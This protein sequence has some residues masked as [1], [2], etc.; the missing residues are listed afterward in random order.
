MLADADSGSYTHL[1]GYGEIDFEGAAQTA[2]SGATNS[3]NPRMRQARPRTL[4]TDLGLHF[5]AG[6]SWS[7]TAPSKPASICAAWMRLASSTSSPFPASL[8]TGNLAFASGR[9]SDRN[10]K[11]RCRPKTPRRPFSAA[12]S[13]AVGTPAVGPQGVLNPESVREPHRSG[14]KLL[15][16]AEQCQP[17]PCPISPAKAAWDPRLGAYRLHVEALGALSRSLRSLRLRQSSASIP[18]AS[19]ATSRRARFRRRW[20]CSLSAQGTLGRLTATPFPD[21]TLEQDGAIQ[22]LTIAAAAVGA[23]WHT[24]PA[25]DLYAYAGLEKTKAD[26]YRCRHGAVRLRQSAL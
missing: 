7:L 13:P 1:A 25:L 23:V 11:S 16:L 14:W 20:I 10:S 17:E 18:R 22:P 24:L 6:Q 8:P 5:L 9:I 26:F 21:A 19:A 15:Q 2:N 12:T 4:R 3:F